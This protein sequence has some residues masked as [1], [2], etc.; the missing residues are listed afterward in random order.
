MPAYNRA[1]I[2]SRAITCVQEQTL[3]DWELIIV[4]DRS[5]DDTEKVVGLFR[6][7]DQRIKFIKNR[8]AKGPAGARNTGIESSQGEFIA[9]LDTD[10]LWLENYLRDSLAALCEENVDICLSLFFQEEN[11]TIKKKYENIAKK[12]ITKLNPLEKGKAFYF[13]NKNICEF[14]I[15]NWAFFYHLNA[16]VIRKRAIWPIGM[17]DERLWGGGRF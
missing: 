3:D 5:T 10:D 8:R 12:I 15:I 9:F 2:I 11:G 14:M 7:N 17:F 13:F 16:T 6:E 1:W 4:D